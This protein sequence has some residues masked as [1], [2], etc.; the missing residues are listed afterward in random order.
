LIYR[1]K[2]HTNY[3]TT[4]LALNKSTFNVF[5]V[6]GKQVA[7]FK[8]SSLSNLTHKTQMV[9]EKPGVY[10]VKA[11]NTSKVYR[12]FVSKKGF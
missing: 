3:K 4:N 2:P 12:V 8:S 6:Q 1:R 9:V 5:T 11:Q 7:Q 10:L